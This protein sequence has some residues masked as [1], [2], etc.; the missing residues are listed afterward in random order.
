MS[1][2]TDYGAW[3][4]YA[5]NGWV[6]FRPPTRLRHRPRAARASPASGLRLLPTGAIGSSSAGSISI[7]NPRRCWAVLRGGRP[8]VRSAPV[9]LPIRGTRR[10]TPTS[11]T[12]SGHS[13]PQTW[14][15]ASC[16]RSARAAS[17]AAATYHYKS[18]EEFLFALA[19][20]MRE[21][22][23]AIIDAGLMLQIDDPGLP[24][25]WDM[26][27]PGAAARGVPQ[28]AACASRR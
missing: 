9:R 28:F 12:S 25:S 26:I 8:T 19:E 11:T 16:A 17:P 5:S 22:Y 21:E 23:K 6:V 10:C 13:R 18:D 7:R 20:A 27:N 1:A 24:D 2:A 15:R 4:N 3:W 14:T